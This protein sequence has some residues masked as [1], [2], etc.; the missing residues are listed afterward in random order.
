MSVYFTKPGVDAPLSLTV[1]NALPIAASNLLGM[2]FGVIDTLVAAQLGA[3]QLAVV[4]IATSILWLVLAPLINLLNGFGIHLIRA[5]GA[6]DVNACKQA[7]YGSVLTGLIASL[8]GAAMLALGFWMYR[9]G[10]MEATLLPSVGRYLV[11]V[12]PTILALLLTTACMQYLRARSTL[13][14]ATCIVV[15]LQPVN[16]WLNWHAADSMGLGVAGIALSTS[17]CKALELVLLML[18]IGRDDY[19]QTL[20]RTR[21]L[22]LEYHLWRQSFRLGVPAYLHGLCDVVVFSA[23]TFTVAAATA[24]DA[25]AHQ[26]L[27]VIACTAY[28]SFG[29]WSSAAGITLG[30]IYGATSARAATKLLPKLTIATLS[31]A[32]VGALFLGLFQ[33]FL[34]GFFKLDSSVAA[35]CR[36]LW[37]LLCA[38]L[39]ADIIQWFAIEALSAFGDTKRPF[40]TALVSWTLPSLIALAAI[41]AFGFGLQSVWLVLSVNMWLMTALL[42]LQLWWLYYRQV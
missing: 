33:E 21:W 32:I 16:Y 27:F 29:A 39:V 10:G 9:F 36:R 13:V 18:W 31:I 20:W 6:G 41:W 1:F 37:P 26:I 11:Y 17:I 19:F 42:L 14:P 38:Y 12:A 23:A 3:N 7:L 22:G 2:A 24:Q 40:L 8:A 34:L 4:A 28:V 15:L 25:A 35:L 5:Y 30:L